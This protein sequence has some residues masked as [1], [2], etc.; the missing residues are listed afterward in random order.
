[1]RAPSRGM[2]F[3]ENCSTAITEGIIYGYSFFFL[4]IIDETKLKSK[5]NLYNTEMI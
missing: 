1:M 3:I 2:L 5:V 4:L